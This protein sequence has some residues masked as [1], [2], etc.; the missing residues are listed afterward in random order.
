LYAATICGIA[1]ILTLCAENAPM[2]APKS[3]A[4]PIRS[5]P[6]KS[7][8]KSVATRAIAMPKAAKVLPERAVSGLRRRRMP[9]MNSAA[10][11][12]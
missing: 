8:T 12:R 10:A 5:R 6:R 1:V 11:A 2:T 3:A 4:I 7:I 9:T